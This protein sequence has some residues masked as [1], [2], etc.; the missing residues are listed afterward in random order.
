M[1][2]GTHASI[3]IEAFGDCCVISCGA[4]IF[5]ID[6]KRII[7]SKYWVVSPEFQSKP[8]YKTVFW[9]LNQSQAARDEIQGKRIPAVNVFQFME[10]LRAF[11]NPADLIWS[12]ATYDASM[13]LRLADK[14]GV[15]KPFSYRNCADLRTL[16]HLVDVK[17]IADFWDKNKESKNHI[18]IDDAMFQ[19]NMVI[20]YYNRIRNRS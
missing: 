20:E 5:S 3:D 18:S 19:A 14:I 11:L 13:L 7:D 17:D 1:D 6:E 16:T 2:L 10:E 4:A 9:W 8:E 12:H 15:R